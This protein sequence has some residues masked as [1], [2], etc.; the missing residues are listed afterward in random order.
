MQ[1]REIKPSATAGRF[2][3]CYW[4]L[5]DD[6]S[7]A[8]V[9]SEAEDNV[10]RIVPDGRTELIFNLG[11]PFASNQDG[12]WKAQPQSFFAGQITGP[13]L[14]R[15]DGP[16]RILGVSFHP[17]RAGRLVGMP[18]Y[19]LTDAAWPLDRILPR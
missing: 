18:V 10:Q 2:I 16:A 19:E 7:P 6:C 5:E 3:K 8:N 14:L 15:S 13:L 11:R 4:M 1:Y 17:H 9:H 12:A